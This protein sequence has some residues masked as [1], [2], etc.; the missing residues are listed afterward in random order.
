MKL[1]IAKIADAKWIGFVAAGIAAIAAFSSSMQ[2]Q[3]TEKT[4]KE[5][6][7]RVSKLETK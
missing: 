7:D 4:I 5:L 1:N 2:E 6:N 3:Q